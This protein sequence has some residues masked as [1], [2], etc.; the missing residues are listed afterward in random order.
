MLATLGRAIAD[1]FANSHHGLAALGHLEPFSFH[2]GQDHHQPGSRPMLT[3]GTETLHKA[4][5]RQ[6]PSIEQ[7]GGTHV[8]P[9]IRRIS[10]A[11][12]G[13]GSGWMH[14]V[15]HETLVVHASSKSQSQNPRHV[16]HMEYVASATVGDSL[17][18]AVA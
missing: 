10:Q 14:G 6:V 1:S 4:L 9:W 16:L 18:L 7:A 17:E 11:V 8:R 5:L 3:R 2:L 13:R 12:R 15:G